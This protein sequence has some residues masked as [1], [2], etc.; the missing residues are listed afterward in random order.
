M[1]ID[2]GDDLVFLAGR[3]LFLGTSDTPGRQRGGEATG[4][5][6]GQSERATEM[7]AGVQP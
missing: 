1:A 3:F 2:D 7:Y 4:N 5:L 6:P